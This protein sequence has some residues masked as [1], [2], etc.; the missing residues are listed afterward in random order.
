[1]PAASLPFRYERKFVPDGLT[2]AEVQALVRRHPAGFRE[3][4][5][6]RTVNNLYLDTPGRRHYREHVNGLANRVKIRLRWYGSLC[7][8]NVMAV[9]ELKIRHGL[10]S[11]KESYPLPGVSLSGGSLWPGLKSALT[12]AALPD[13]ARLQVNN[14]EPAVTNRY[15]RRYY[16][17]A[18]ST[19]RLTVD[20]E[21]E[22]FPPR[23]SGLIQRAAS[24][25]SPRV[26]L[27]LKYSEANAEQASHVAGDFPFRLTRCSKYIL[28][29]E[30]VNGR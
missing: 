20:T 26:I 7:A 14:L 17:S 22:F 16:C 10:L 13:T 30:Q 21:L 9:L 11:R 5:P 6:P 12:V 8:S 19:V 4:Y 1:M 25:E 15:H 3:V 24:H 27:E 29:V 23:N 18:D 2:V 28:G